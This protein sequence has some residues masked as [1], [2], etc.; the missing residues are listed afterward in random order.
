MARKKEFLFQR[1][2]R[3]KAIATTGSFFVEEM[4]GCGRR[5]RGKERE[6]EYPKSLDFGVEQT[7]SRAT[8]ADR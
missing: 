4:E 5:E 3:R 1:S 8:W 2:F 7:G 6:R